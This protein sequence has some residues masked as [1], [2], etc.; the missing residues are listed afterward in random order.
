MEL[1]DLFITPI[2]LIVLYIVAYAI[3][4]SVTNSQTKKYFIPALTVKFIGAIALGLIYQFYYGG[5]DT[6]NYFQQSK[7]IYNAFQ[8]SF[9]TG[10]KLMLSNG[11]FDPDLINYTS[12]LYW[13]R[14]PAEFMIIKITSIFGLFSF[15]TYSVIA[16]FFAFF[17][18]TGLWALYVT[19]LKLYPNLHKQLAWAVFFIPTVF[20]WGSGL[21]KDTIC[22]G[23]MG[24]MFWAF[25]KALIER[26]SFVYTIFIFLI[27]AWLINVIKKYI[28]LAFLPGIL[29][30]LF[31][32]YNKKIKNPLLR[33]L[34]MP[35]SLA[36]GLGLA[37]FAATNVT[38]GDKLYGID[39]LAERTKITAD[40]LYSVSVKQ[41]GSAYR[42]GDL[43]GTFG[44]MLKLAPQ[45][46]NV[47]LFRP[48]VWE[49]K[50]PLML[51]SALESFALLI[52]TLS[53]LYRVGIIKVGKKIISNPY[54][55]FCLIF[56]FVFAFAVGIN[57]N[58]FGTLVRY[59][60]PFVP[61][62]ASLLLI[63]KGI[64]DKKRLADSRKSTR[65][66]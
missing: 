46:I 28:L 54:L 27:N 62:Y 32:E 31:L 39:K 52:S 20:F 24:W 41:E 30:W 47:S 13:Y 17:S 34:S 51:L 57:S 5:G 29:F 3:R 11:E 23:A 60:I 65:F 33:K 2:Y 4:S 45:A 35:F 12:R 18:F 63:I 9:S 42:L 19:I 36:A 37:Y 10:F 48:Y 44:G 8:S 59:K 66:A 14:A 26:K 22:L 61:F 16:L 7:I 1:K 21:L 64:P 38:A 6:Y 40:Y 58:N 43:D 55:L 25:Y 49:V 56:T 15:Q 53:I 50:N